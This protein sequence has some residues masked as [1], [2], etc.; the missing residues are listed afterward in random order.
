M[1]KQIKR[2]PQLVDLVVSLDSKETDTKKYSLP[3]FL[4]MIVAVRKR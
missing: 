1:Q 4:F 3:K 2:N